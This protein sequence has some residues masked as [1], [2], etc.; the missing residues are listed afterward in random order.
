MKTDMEH[1]NSIV[2][3]IIEEY[4]TLFEGKN[5]SLD[6]DDESVDG[7]ASFRRQRR[8]TFRKVSASSP[9]TTS[10]VGL[11]SSSPPPIPSFTHLSEPSPPSSRTGGTDPPTNISTN[12]NLSPMTIGRPG[13]SPSI[14]LSSSPSPTQGG[15]GGWAKARMPWQ[16]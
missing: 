9:A 4:E 8:E 7:S 10:A 15:A 5:V 11:L 13:A 2:E 12:S 6:E 1:G 16:T 14:S 3:T